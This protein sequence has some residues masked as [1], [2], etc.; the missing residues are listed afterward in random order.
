M[1]RAG[2]RVKTRSAFVALFTIRAQAYGS[3]RWSAYDAK[4]GG[5]PL[6]FP[7]RFRHPLT[8]QDMLTGQAFFQRKRDVLAAIEAAW[9]RI[10]DW[11]AMEAWENEGGAIR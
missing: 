10:E 8:G 6:E 1:V 5:G 3:H 2:E 4:T 11:R 9:Q 7:V